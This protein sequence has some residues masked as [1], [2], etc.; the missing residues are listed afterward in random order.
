[1]L[2][3]WNGCQSGIIRTTVHFNNIE[4]IRNEANGK[5]QI[6]MCKE[7]T[8]KH[9]EVDEFAASLL[10]EVMKNPKMVPNPRLNPF[11]MILNIKNIKPG[12]LISS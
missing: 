2:S 4:F 8:N 1:M 5:S 7:N 9:Q 6:N 11:N 10:I 12:F 3:K